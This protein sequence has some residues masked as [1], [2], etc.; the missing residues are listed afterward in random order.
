M[1][2]SP[3]ASIVLFAGAALLLVSLI[4]SSWFKYEGEDMSMSIGL[5]RSQSCD[6]T[7]G[8]RSMGLF[9]GGGFGGIIGL[10]VAVL[11]LGSMV[12]SVITAFYCL[13]PYRTALAAVTMGI[14]SGTLLIGLLYV[15]RGMGVGFGYGV[16]VFFLG[17]G[18]V[19]TGSIMGMTRPRPP[20][21]ARPA[22]YPP[23]MYG[24][25]MYAPPPQHVAPGSSP[26]APPG[27]PTY[28]PPCPT[29]T[30]P[31][32]WIAQYSRMLCSKCNRYL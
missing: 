29:C 27:P 28:G 9:G 10:L 11:V 15:F 4:S 3:L 30:T 19:L 13:K 17:A 25:N 24:A 14:V 1:K 8:C 7:Y 22:M 6:S 5:I 23:Q 32:M 16:P 18:A 2:P 12:L 20:Q 26:Y 31:T 21:A